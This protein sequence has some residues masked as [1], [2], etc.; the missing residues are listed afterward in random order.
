MDLSNTEDLRGETVFIQILR[1]SD[2]E[3]IL[4]PVQLLTGDCSASKTNLTQKVT[5]PS[6]WEHSQLALWARGAHGESEQ[7]NLGLSEFPGVN[8]SLAEPVLSQN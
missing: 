4:R 5:Q 6:S 2:P 7:D 1:V 3:S 8:P